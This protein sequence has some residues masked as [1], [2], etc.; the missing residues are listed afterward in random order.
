MGGYKSLKEGDEVDFD[1]V[2]GPKGPQADAVT[3]STA[4][5]DNMDDRALPLGLRK[6]VHLNVAE[7][8]STLRLA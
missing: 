4:Q 5:A 1:I 8:P 2:L 7:T 6:F 3:R